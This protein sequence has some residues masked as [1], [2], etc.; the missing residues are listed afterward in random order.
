[1]VREFEVVG[2]Q[3]QRLMSGEIDNGIY[4]IFSDWR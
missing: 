1:M 2:T 4:R 3:G